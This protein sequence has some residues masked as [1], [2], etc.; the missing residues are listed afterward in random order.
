M[1]LSRRLL[2]RSLPL[3][4][5]LAGLLLTLLLLLPR[6]WVEAAWFHQFDLVGVLLRRWGFQLLAFLLVLGLGIPLQLQQLQRCWVLRRPGGGRPSGG[7]PESSL[8]LPLG[9]WSLALALVLLLG[10]LAIGLTY[11]LE[12][13]RGLI[14]EP[15]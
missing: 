6:L 3:L 2:S 8:L 14:N 4:L 10:L 5:L 11:L 1:A 9:G 13:A 7:R 12:Q 15:F